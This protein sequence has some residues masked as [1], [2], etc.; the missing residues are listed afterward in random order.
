MPLSVKI[1][2]KLWPRMDLR[3]AET[4]IHFFPYQWAAPTWVW[5]MT[6]LLFLLRQCLKEGKKKIRE[7]SLKGSSNQ[8]QIL[9]WNKLEWSRN[10]TCNVSRVGRTSIY[11]GLDPLSSDI[12][13][14]TMTWRCKR[15]LFMTWYQNHCLHSLMSLYALGRKLQLW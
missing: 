6:V 10:H 3:D 11:P 13:R 2:V 4:Q 8:R 9:L 5:S 12:N 15:L 14:G 7:L 1:C